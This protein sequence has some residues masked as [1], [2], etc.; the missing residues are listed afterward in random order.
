MSGQEPQTSLK[1]QRRDNTFLLVG[2]A[3]RFAPGISLFKPNLM[4]TLFR[5]PELCRCG[6]SN[7]CLL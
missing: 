5:D 7:L 3:T 4:D 6:R 2:S 1:P